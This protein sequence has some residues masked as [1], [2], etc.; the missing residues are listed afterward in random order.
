MDIR[1]EPALCSYME[2]TGKT[3]ILVEMVE[4][5]NTDLE[6][7][8]LHIRF[9]NPRTRDQFVNQKNYRVI[10]TELG[11]V[12]L[13]RFPLQLDEVIT[14]GLKSFLFFHHVTCKGIKV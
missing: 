11:E 13:P 4:I 5:N 6:I 9:P 3:T 12:L 14:F 8:E 7:N 2:K 10:E 1:Y